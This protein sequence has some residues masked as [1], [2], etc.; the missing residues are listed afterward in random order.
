[1]STKSETVVVGAAAA[2]IG[3]FLALALYKLYEKSTQITWRS[4]IKSRKV[5]IKNNLNNINLDKMINGKHY[6]VDKGLVDLLTQ[7]HRI[8][9]LYNQPEVTTQER[10]EMLI[11][12][13]HTTG[14]KKPYIEAPIHVD[15]GFNISVGD[16]FYCNFNCVL[17]DCAKITIG[18]NVFLAPGVQLLTAS[19]PINAIERRSVEFALPVTIGDDV[20]I[21]ANALILPGV[22]IG[23]R[24]VIAAGAVVNKD[25]PDDVVV[26]GVP[27]KI[28]KRMV[29]GHNFESENN[30]L[31]RKVLR[32]WK[33]SNP[34]E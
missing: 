29:E 12:L 25:V 13:F 3:G 10:Q 30:E 22:T 6:V 20:W 2:L 15:Y 4:I 26:A 9:D 8:C 27:A 11:H 31:K 18:N 5:T 23:S 7:A 32:L 14:K 17:L 34:S 19:H 21:G 24:V 16:N 28:V 1:M 33:L